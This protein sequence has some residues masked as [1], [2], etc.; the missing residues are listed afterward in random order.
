MKME[1]ASG[2]TEYGVTSRV[3]FAHRAAM[4]VIV[5]GALVIFAIS[6]LFFQQ[7]NVLMG[8]GMGVMGVTASSSFYLHWRMMRVMKF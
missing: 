5:L 2:V 6:I 4:W 8:V 1:D 3:A 7:G